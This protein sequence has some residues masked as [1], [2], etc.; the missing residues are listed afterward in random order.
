MLGRGID[1]ILPHP[2]DP[3]IFESVAASAVLYRELAEKANGP[4]PTPAPFA[5]VWGNLLADLRAAKIDARIVNLETSIT[6]SSEPVPKGINYRMNPANVG[7][8]TELPVDCCTLANN[9]LLDWGRAGLIE[10]LATLDRAGI[11]HAGAGRNSEEAA[12]PAIIGLSD[13]GRVLVFGFGSP[14]S[15]VPRAWA[16]R[17]DQPG[18]MLLDDLSAATFARVA[19]RV[20]RAKQPGDLVIAS[21]HWGGNWGYSVPREQQRFAHALIGD[22][23]VDIVHGHSSHH[24]K[25]IEIYRGK[26]IL[27]GCGDLVNDYEGI[28]GYEAFRS[29]LVLGYVAK[30]T[31]PSGQLAR[32][33]LLPFQLKHF[34]LNHPPAEAIEWLCGMLERESAAFASRVAFETGEGKLNARCG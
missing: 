30:C 2:G 22:A 20:H 31:L 18:I 8:L 1:Q 28:G 3:R 11:A 4:I 13:H 10:T 21:I 17:V 14:S 32:L 16:A 29:D 6:T 19:E 34:R 33:E 15:G 7:V 26:L 9:H 23:G 24:P 25:G 12:T 27:Y 5:Y